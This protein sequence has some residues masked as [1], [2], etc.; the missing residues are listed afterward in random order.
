MKCL[1]GFPITR[2][3]KSRSLLLASARRRVEDD[4]L[5]YFTFGRPL[6]IQPGPL[7]L[8]S[9]SLSLQVCDYP[10]INNERA[11]VCQERGG[12]PPLFLWRKRRE[13]AQ[14]SECETSTES[15]LLSHTYKK[16]L[17]RLTRFVISVA[18]CSVLSS[19]LC[20]QSGLSN[21]TVLKI[22]SATPPPSTPTPHLALCGGRR[23][24]GRDDDKRESHLAPARGPSNGCQGS[25][26]QQQLKGFF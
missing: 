10:I 7:S 3:I 18:T 12:K 1:V 20:N 13:C 6:R 17:M 8:S 11:P 14:K 26:K 19:P 25:Q 9:F 23:V 16:T 21:R 24:R 5:Q 2:P 15:R 4:P 22:A